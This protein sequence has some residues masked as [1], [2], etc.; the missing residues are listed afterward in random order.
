MAGCF[1]SNAT[2]PTDSKTRVVDPDPDGSALIWVAGSGSSFHMPIQIQEGINDPQ[3]KNKV[4]KFHVLN[5]WMS[6]LRAEGSSCSLGVPYRGLGISKLQFLIE[7]ISIFFSFI[8]FSIF[9]NQNPG[10]RTG[11]GFV[12]GSAVNQCGSA[13]LSKTYYIHSYLINMLTQKI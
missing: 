3:K 12:S 2:S 6:L 9:A 13:I 11:S 7:K 4:K 8:C 1:A 5:C 10:S